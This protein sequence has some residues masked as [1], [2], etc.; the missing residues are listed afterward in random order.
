MFDLKYCVTCLVLVDIDIFESSKFI[1]IFRIAMLFAHII[2]VLLQ[3]WKIIDKQ[4]VREVI[5]H[6]F[7]SL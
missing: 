2:V 5:F 7:I 6:I 1:P 3:F 4:A